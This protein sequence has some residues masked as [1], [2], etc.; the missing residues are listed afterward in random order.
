MDFAAPENT[1]IT[2]LADGT[3]TYT[4]RLGDYGNLVM[5]KHVDGSSSRYA[6][7]NSIIASRGQKVKAGT[8]IGKSGGAKGNP[9]AG[10]S[11]GAHLHFEYLNS[12]GQKVNPA[13]FLKGIKSSEPKYSWTGH[14]R[15]N[16]MSNP[17]TAKQITLSSLGS[18]SLSALLS[19]AISSGEPIS[20]DDIASKSS[21]G[22]L[23]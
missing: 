15:T 5:I 13:P 19:S 4:G 2:S 20:W 1:P 8:V 23:V 12:A 10:N 16:F 22:K 18:P 7:L 11:T 9:G 21:G 14:K 3:V 17:K 6:H